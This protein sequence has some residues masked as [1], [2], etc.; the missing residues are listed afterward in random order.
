VQKAEAAARKALELGPNLAE[1]HHA[2]AKESFFFR[3]DWAGAERS[4]LRALELNPRIAECR[5]YYALMLIV[6][7]RRDEALAQA[8][9]A[10]DDDP[11][12][13]IVNTAMVLVHLFTGQ[14][15]AGLTRAHRALQLDPNLVLVRQVLSF[16]YEQK[17]DFDAAIDFGGPL[18]AMAP[19]VDAKAVLTELRE[20]WKTRG[21]RG[22]WEQRLQMLRD[23]A[24]RRYVPPFV[25]AYVYT[26]LDDFDRAFEYLERAYTV[27]S[28]MIVFMGIDYAYAPLRSDPRFDALLRKMG[29][30]K[31]AS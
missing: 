21:K 28:G 3:R 19:G 14:F 17:E 6:L 31:I 7:G 12:S 1:A 20:A 13:G 9:Q 4:F 2:H 25:W 8:Q 15:D 10:L 26:R 23:M 5:M 24:A 27:S 11:L 18:M 22:Y 29:L 16:V 30:P